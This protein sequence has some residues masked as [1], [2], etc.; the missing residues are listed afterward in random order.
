MKRV[1]E[2]PIFSKEPGNIK[3]VHSR[4]YSGLISDKVDTIFIFNLLKMTRFWQTLHISHDDNAISVVAR[5]PQAS[6]HQHSKGQHK[7]TLR[8][9]SGPRR[10]HGIVASQA[11]LGYRPD[12]RTVRTT[13]F[14]YFDY[15][16][17]FLGPQR[18]RTRDPLW[19]SI[20]V[21]TRWATSG[22]CPL[23][24]GHECEIRLGLNDQYSPRLLSLSVPVAVLPA[25]HRLV[26]A[27][28]YF[29]A[30]FCFS[31]LL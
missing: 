27:D 4:K 3:N 23:G 12:L 22:R 9:R 18:P 7:A 26:D 11:R 28:T 29:F 25:V 14:M 8:P 21:R 16:I 24:R 1:P 15:V 19:N 6:I 30:I 2:G 31:C 17:S 13:P 5:K 10:A 20:N